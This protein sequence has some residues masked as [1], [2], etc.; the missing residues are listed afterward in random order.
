MNEM[1]SRKGNG[2]VGGGSV[3]LILPVRV[4]TCA[5]DVDRTGECQ[6][7]SWGMQPARA[8][9]GRDGEAS[10]RYFA[11]RRVGR[12]E[13]RASTLWAK[14]GI[15]PRLD[16]L[17]GVHAV[18]PSGFS[19]AWRGHAEKMAIH[20]DQMKSHVVPTRGSSRASGV[21]KATPKGRVMRR[22]CEAVSGSTDLW[23][24]SRAVVGP[25]VEGPK[26]ET[27]LSEHTFRVVVI[28]KLAAPA[29]AT[30][31][32]ARPLSGNPAPP[33]RN[34]PQHPLDSVCGCIV[35]GDSHV[36]DH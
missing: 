10:Q 11:G 34:V 30:K 5:E 31:W 36:Q 17:E 19:G 13:V 6:T 28:G 33:L 9:N 32:P 16:L 8:S 12:S 14:H 29:E 23:D 1:L 27:V 7:G 2:A 20:S 15:E 24:G 26:R 35:T 18:M 22:I 25:S 4:R 3:D 21:Y